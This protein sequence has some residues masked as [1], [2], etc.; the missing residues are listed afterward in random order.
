MFLSWFKYTQFVKNQHIE[1]YNQNQN[2]FKGSLKSD[3]YELRSVRKID[4]SLTQ[5]YRV[6]GRGGARHFHLGGH[7]RGQ[8]CNKGRCQWSV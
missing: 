1:N 2:L 5:H 7:W 3:K 8:F 6:R 4:R